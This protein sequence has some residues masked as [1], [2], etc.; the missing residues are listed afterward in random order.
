M[1]EQLQAKV[2]AM[3]ECA[4]EMERIIERMK[5]EET[6]KKL[7]AIKQIGHLEDFYGDE[8][9]KQLKEYR[10][11]KDIQKKLNIATAKTLM[12]I[13]DTAKSFSGDPVTS[14]NYT[15]PVEL[16]DAAECIKLLPN[17]FIGG[18]MKSAL[19]NSSVKVKKIALD[20]FDSLPREV[21]YSEVFPPN[22]TKLA[23]KIRSQLGA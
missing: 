3:D 1:D 18:P 4:K 8:E 17:A 9:M 20:Y 19:N 21:K 5:A 13:L 12:N 11:Y 10:E 16:L 7:E 2:A 23:A 22:F 6:S 14:F 15:E